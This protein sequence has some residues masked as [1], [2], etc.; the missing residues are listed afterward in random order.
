MVVYIAPWDKEKKSLFLQLPK[1]PTLYFEFIASFEL[2]TRG[3]IEFDLT[4][5]W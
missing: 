1:F 3:S 5:P 2:G 4:H